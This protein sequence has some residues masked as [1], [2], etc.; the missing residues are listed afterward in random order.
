M[1]RYSR[2]FHHI[3]LDDVKRNKIKSEEKQ[4]DFF[5]TIREARN[6]L[7]DLNSPHYSN[8][9]E[10][11]LKEGMTTAGMMLTTF[12][13]TGESNLENIDTG[14]EG[15]FTA[16]GGDA[17]F[18]GTVVRASGSGEGSDGGFDVGGNY[19]GFEDSADRDW[20]T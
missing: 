10:P 3:S 7:R 19:L 4:K 15:S 13:S 1:N 16:A 9:R 20:E 8:W 11:D 17:A 14:N 6:F 5:K 12:P 18:N 2:V